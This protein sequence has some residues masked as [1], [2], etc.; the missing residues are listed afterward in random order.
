MDAM[1]ELYDEENKL[2]RDLVRRHL[3]VKISSAIRGQRTAE[4][5]KLIYLG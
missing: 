4:S 2:V 3:S 1:V 5:S